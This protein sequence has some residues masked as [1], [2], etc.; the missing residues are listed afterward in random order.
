MKLLLKNKRYYKKKKK[1]LNF[2][3]LLIIY[4]IY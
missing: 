4:D 2:K 3:N 1:N